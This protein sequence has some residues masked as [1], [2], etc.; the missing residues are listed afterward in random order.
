MMIAF[1]L[2]AA[3]TYIFL[4]P[5][6]ASTGRSAGCRLLSAFSRMY[7]CM[8]VCMYTEVARQYIRQRQ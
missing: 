7:V 1:F 8:H 5:E 6:S 2:L 4:I 3:T